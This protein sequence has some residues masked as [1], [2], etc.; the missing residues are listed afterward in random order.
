MEKYIKKTF[1]ELGIQINWLGYKMWL[2][3]A[4]IICEN[5]NLQMEEVYYEVAKKH[6]STKSKTERAMRYSI[7]MVGQKKLQDF[8]KVNYKI[9]CASFLKL[10]HESILTFMEQEILSK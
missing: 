1:N 2:T 10:L 9:T 3:A 7:G 8:F 4:K 6:K 5:E